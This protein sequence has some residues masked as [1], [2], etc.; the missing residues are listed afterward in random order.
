[1]SF[2]GFFCFKLWWPFCSV[3][4]NDFSNFGRGHQKTFLGNYFEMG[5]LVQEEMSF[6]GFSFFSFGCHF[7]QWQFC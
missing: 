3:E 6:K 7:V 4:R 1:M 5:P 2:E